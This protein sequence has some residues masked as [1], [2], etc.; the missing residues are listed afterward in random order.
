M[1]MNSI[2]IAVLL[3]QAQPVIKHGTCP[4][5]YTQSGNYCAPTQNAPS[6]IPKVGQCPSGWAT[7]GNYCIEMKRGRG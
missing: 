1:T 6:A 4:S 5:G 2:L 7:S 3:A